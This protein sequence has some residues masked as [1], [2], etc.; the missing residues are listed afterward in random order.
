MSYCD[1]CKYYRVCGDKHRDVPCDGYESMDETVTV[2]D[3]ILLTD[4]MPI[5]IRSAGLDGW[6]A[7]NEMG[8]INK[9]FHDYDVQSIRITD[10]YWNGYCNEQVMLL[11]V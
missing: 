5:E 1:G 4:N 9:E 6:L 11:Y 2:I 8:P 10:R 7:D 3:M